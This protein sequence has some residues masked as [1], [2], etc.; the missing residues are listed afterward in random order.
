MKYSLQVKDSQGNIIHNPSFKTL[1]EAEKMKVLCLDLKTYPQ[2]PKKKVIDV[3][4]VFH[5]IPAEPAVLDEQGNIIKDAIPEIKIIDSP[6]VSH[7]E[8]DYT[9]EILDKSADDEAQKTKQALKEQKYQDR[10]N[11]LKALDWS[12]I[13]TVADIKPILKLLVED[14]L[15][16]Q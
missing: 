4:E 14:F 6:E 2:F 12:T 15:K 10:I 9:V 8:P 5:I 13:K 16:D 3:A 1:E 7:L 11:Q